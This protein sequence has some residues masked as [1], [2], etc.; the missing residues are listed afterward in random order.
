MRA[1]R[2]WDPTESPSWCASTTCPRA[3]GSSPAGTQPC[4][5]S[6]STSWAREETLDAN[7]FPLG[8]NAVLVLNGEL[9]VPLWRDVGVVAFLDGGNVFRR[10][11]DFDLRR[12]PRRRRLWPAV[13]LADRTAAFRSRIQARSPRAAQ[14]SAGA[15]DRAV[16][17]PG[18]GLLMA[19]RTRATA[20]AF[21]CAALFAA[22][23]P[24]RGDDLLDRVLATVE[25]RVITLS[26][27]R[28]AV[29]LRAG[30]GRRAGR[31]DGRIARSADQP[32]R[33]P[34]R[35]RAIRA[36]GAGSGCDPRGEWRRSGRA[37]SS[38]EARRGAARCGTRRGGAHAVGPQRPAHR[39]VSAGT[40][41]G[42]R[43]ADRGGHRG[44]HPAAR[45]RPAAHADARSTIR[46]FGGWRGSGRGRAAARRWWP[47]GCRGCGPAPA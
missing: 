21:A 33:D 41:R 3:S 34:G 13:S 12:G 16:H 8:G 14:R 10:V 20:A 1:V 7:G 17:Q 23:S 36:A 4:A 26:D 24:G 9:R 27:V 32:A 47:S 31:R 42:R 28:T 11:D 19:H 5:D 43:R 40:V 35:G 44:L 37:S 18:A 30:R 22:A 2:C 29:Q 39:A 46:R 6:G 38:E 25:G 45:G 15:A